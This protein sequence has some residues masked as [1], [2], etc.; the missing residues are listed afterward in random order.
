MEVG[1]TVDYDPQQVISD[2]NWTDR[3]PIKQV[4]MNCNC[5][6]VIQAVEGSDFFA[7]S[8]R[9]T[10]ELSQNCAMLFTPS[11]TGNCRYQIPGSQTW[12]S[13][14]LEH[15]RKYNKIRNAGE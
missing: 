14:M 12:S 6:T 1:L 2:I 7:L 3:H 8:M 10:V 5:Y 15:I 13:Q 4:Y 11:A 9:G